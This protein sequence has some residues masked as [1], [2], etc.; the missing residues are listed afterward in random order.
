MSERVRPWET[1]GP[2]LCRRGPAWDPEAPGSPPC[3]KKLCF[4]ATDKG[5]LI[6]L[7]DELSDRPDCW[8]V[9]Y[10]VEP[11]DGMHLGR[12]FLNDERT[13]GG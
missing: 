8:A 5:F 2:Y 4:V 9:K 1:Q 12:C 6:G 3:N 10:S 13:I 11:R 7:L